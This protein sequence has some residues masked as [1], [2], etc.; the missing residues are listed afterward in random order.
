MKIATKI[1]LAFLYTAIIIS[2]LAS[3]I[4]YLIARNFVERSIYAH[5]YT[6]IE[7]RK[8]H[9]ETYLDL[10]KLSVLEL[11][12]SVVLEGFL[13][14]DIKSPARAEN[15]AVAMK[16][17]AATKS[18]NPHIYEFLLCDKTGMVVAST[19]KASIGLDRSGDAYFVGGQKQAYIKDA[20]YSDIFKMPLMAASAPI[21]NS[22]T[23]QFLGIIVAR[24]ELNYF[25]GI[26]AERTGLGESGEIY[27]VNKYG[28]MVTPSKFKAQTFLRQRVEFCTNGLDSLPHKTH[29]IG[30]YPGYRGVLVLGTSEYIPQMQWHIVA[31]LDRR[32]A[33]A[34]LVKI[35]ILFLAI[36]FLVPLAAWLIGAFSS[37]L[38]ARPIH[39]LHVG[40]EII[41]AGNLDYKVSTTARDEIGQLSRAFDQMTEELKKSRD[42]LQELAGSLEEKVKERTEELS[43]SQEA[44]LNMLEDLTEAKEKL[45]KYTQE[46]E[47]ALRVKSDFTSMVSHELRTPLTAIKEGISI[48][49]DG[50]AG[51]INAEQKEFL[52]IAKNNVDRL[53]RLINE[54]L[55]F[56]KLE[57]GR[58]VFNMQEHDINEI[59]R[60]V[61]KSMLA[62]AEG[63]GLDFILK[64]DETSPRIKFDQDKIIQ[65][66]INLVNNAIKFTD[67]GSVTIATSRSNNVILV[68][69]GDTGAGIKSEDIPRLFQKFEQLG[70][71]N[72]RKTGG[73]GLGLAISKEIIEGHRGK[74][75]AES[76]L[77]E[78]T[79]FHFV[80]PIKERRG[81][82]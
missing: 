42:S 77:G 40:T 24:I 7:S 72:E 8:E 76:K 27:I 22:S 74:I 51:A 58:M 57:S 11:S 17:L 80:L 16:R 53:A 81:A 73:T 59:A 34:P 54:V 14:T 37:G 23:G 1:S 29:R 41:G 21:F 78:G 31:E 50:S 38:I 44:S 39:N 26:V 60:G 13:N 35:R 4:F 69:V 48:V 45:N 9:V 79:V 66:L 65:V 12:K 19:N 49:L 6:T 67:K 61:R 56:Q 63:K 70:R 10:L 18:V 3:S 64:L 68:S 55:D 46:L 71:D 43:R 2:T 33:L 30:V 20:Y 62:L 75:W 82:V 36:L 25:Y 5:L 47:E 28:F 52:E 32:E 15:F